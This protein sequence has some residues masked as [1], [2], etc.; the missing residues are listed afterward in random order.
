MP[1]SDAAQSDACR[2]FLYCDDEI[3][4]HAHRARGQTE[5]VAEPADDPE[6][7]TTRFGAALGRADGHQPVD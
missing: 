2:A 7:G 1:N 4:G 5:L 3:V 6:T